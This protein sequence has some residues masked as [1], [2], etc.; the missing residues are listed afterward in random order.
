MEVNPMAQGRNGGMKTLLRNIRTFWFNGLFS[1]VSALNPPHQRN[2]TEMEDQRRLADPVYLE[3][4]GFKVYSQN[5]EDGIIEEIF[6]RIGTVNKT[7]I[8]FGVQNG[9]ESNGHFLLHK[10]WRGLWIDG[11]AEYC[12][13]INT[14][15]AKPIADKRLTVLNAF[16]TKD[17][18]NTLITQSGYDGGGGKSPDLLSIDIDG[19]DWWVWKAI[20]RI[21]PRVVVI[22]Y[23][24]K[25]PPSFEY[26]MDYK[27]DYV[28]G[29]FDE[30]GA[31][32]KALERLGREKGYQLVGTNMNGVNAFFVKRELARDL[33]P[34]PATAENLYNPFRFSGRQY[35]AGYPAKEYIGR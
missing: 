15:F 7:F 1:R 5:D 26:V 30:H 4:Y 23:N 19:N 16:I 25:F 6:R 31:S 33:F 28:W 34:E 24:G 3:R 29:G 20:D 18:I 11:G 13:E 32:L 14:L 10:G 9:L 35:A 22:E 12:R 21:E 27:A 2:D 17:N 8:E